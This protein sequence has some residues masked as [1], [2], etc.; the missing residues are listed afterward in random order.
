MPPITK[1]I[2]FLKMEEEGM[3][4]Q[5]DEI[6]KNSRDNPKNML[7]KNRGSAVFAL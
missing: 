2:P 6:T 4:I 3:N 5:K 1:Y 7:K